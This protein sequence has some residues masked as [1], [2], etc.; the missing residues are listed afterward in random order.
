[1]WPYSNQWRSIAGT[2]HKHAVAKLFYNRAYHNNLLSEGKTL[3]GIITQNAEPGGYHIIAYRL[4]IA[5]MEEL[6]MQWFP[7]G[8][9][10]VAFLSRVYE[11]RGEVIELRLHGY[12]RLAYAL[13]RKNSFD[14]WLHAD[15]EGLFRVH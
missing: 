4:Y 3:S 1:M 11:H 12:D 10:R 2:C 15:N 7:N 13:D 6:S 8:A 5:M 9:Q 14:N